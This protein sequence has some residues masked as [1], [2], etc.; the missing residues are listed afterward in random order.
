MSHDDIKVGDL[1]VIYDRFGDDMLLKKV[2]RITKTTLV[3][4]DHTFSR[5]TGRIYGSSTRWASICF[6]PYIPEQHN[7]RLRQS[8]LKRR[9]V[10]A[11]KALA[12]VTVTE[13]NVE[14]IEAFIKELS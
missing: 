5:S 6:A 12:A 9:L 13:E 7:E 10:R 1:V 4:G 11:R 2:T 3:A 14:K 8:Q